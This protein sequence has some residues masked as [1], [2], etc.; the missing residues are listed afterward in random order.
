[1]TNPLIMVLMTW[2]VLGLLWAVFY[3]T[4]HTALP[5]MAPL[6]LSE[7]GGT[8]T[9]LLW[10]WNI[11]IVVLAISTGI[12]AMRPPTNQWGNSV[13][14]A[15]T[16]AFVCVCCWAIL[17]IFWAIMYAPLNH[18]I[19]DAFFAV[20]NAR[21]PDYLL[22]VYNSGFTLLMLGVGFGTLAKQT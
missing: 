20:T 1:M 6:A 21:G 9:V 5:L 22:S 4:I 12:A 16:G 14:P 19:P 10:T 3:D 7:S 13:A 8:W 17:I 2:A 15:V 11:G 18:T